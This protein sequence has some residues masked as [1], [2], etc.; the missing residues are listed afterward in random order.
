MK[1]KI[2][3]FKN[4]IK[5]VN[6]KLKII[7]FLLISLILNLISAPVNAS[8][9]D[10]SYL[11]L[12]SQKPNT[13]L[14]GTV[15]ANP[16]SIGAGTENKVVIAFP[17]EFTI[18][19]TTS[20]WTTNI[21]NLPTGATAWPGINAT[22]SNVSGQGVTFASSDLTSNTLYCFNFTGVSSTTGNAGNDQTG[23]ITTQNSS[24]A[25]IDLTNY[26]TS[27]VSNNEISVTA[28]VDP[29]VS[30]LPI[31]IE[32]TTA[33]TQFSQDKTISYKI[34]YGSNTIGTIPL[35]IQASWSQGTIAG[36]G[37]PSVDILDYV[38]GSA[39][40]A[41][42]STAPVI[43]T[44]N[45]TITW[46]I[47]SFPGST[48]GQTT[49]FNLKTNTSYTG[50]S[51]VSFTI[52]ANATSGST[53]TP[54]STVDQTYLYQNTTPTSTPTPTQS[55]TTTTTTSTPTPT[56][57][58]ALPVSFDS[59]EIRSISQTNTTVFVSTTKPTKMK[60]IYGTSPNNLG[61]TIS[62]NNFSD[63]NIFNLGNLETNS[64][65]FFK[66]FATDI[67][68]KTITSDTFTFITAN[69]PAAKINENSIVVISK[70]NI[71][72]DTVNT[73]KVKLEDNLIIIPQ[74]S[75]F[76][77]NFS[78]KNKESI[79]KAKLI[80]RK[81]KSFANKVLG[82]NNFIKEVE[83]A[84]DNVSLLEIKPGVY[85]ATIR[86]NNEPG[87]YELIANYL[88]NNGNLTEIK[89]ADIKVTNPFTVINKDNDPIEGARVFL[90]AYN[91]NSRV[92]IPLSFG[93][94]NIN[95]P[96]FTDNHGIDDFVLP[97]GKYKAN[98]NDHFYKEKNVIFTINDNEQA[99]YPI[100]TMD[101]DYFN[102]I[103]FVK[104]YITSFND[105]FVATT[106]AYIDSLNISIR[107][108][109]LVAAAILL[110]FVSIALFAF[111][112]KHHI[113]LSSF[114][115]YVFYLLNHKERNKKYINGAVFDQYGKPVPLANVYL[116]DVESE[117]IIQSTKTNGKG[118]FFFKKGTNKYLLMVMKKGYQPTPQLP[119]EEKS[120]ASFKITMEEKNLKTEISDKIFHTTSALIGI[121]FETFM[122]LSL[123]FEILFIPSFGVTKT[124]PFICVSIFNLTLW[125]LHARH[126]H[127]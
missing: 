126:H 52:S 11:R 124:L 82:F 80:L 31:A 56:I 67:S 26:A 64:Q 3:M 112:K 77:F 119:Y 58:P 102:L 2:I 90:Y 78:F 95:N 113:P 94:L 13:A 121:F 109:D 50:S 62:Y 107:F 71:I 75:N 65:Y 24:N 118:E 59:L 38:V 30:D 116:T 92:F 99:N 40:N 115:S 9:F 83:A 53:V 104:Y 117:Q 89:L 69:A 47:S 18:S 110:S 41:Y 63:I 74:N 12:N 21:S 27:I 16:S 86:S 91:E 72:F 20:N 45:R 6:C 73:T 105:V 43:D 70:N 85:T 101:R 120:D 42:N 125:V 68:G 103:A 88:D 28:A 48:T 76:Q 123:F 14:S 7:F 98:I 97:K 37:S 111:S 35:T 29:Q 96:S 93:N 1:F 19:Q 5:I 114:F 46:T 81:V 60:L 34:T 84:N 17:S 4:S 122:L 10:S 25:T 36:N 66:I 55:S 32:S 33:G 57:T 15:C 8:S 61:T 54:N 87:Y 39:S 49:T 79:K 127:S 106:N 44:I 51:V 22:A 108:F 100:I 23:F